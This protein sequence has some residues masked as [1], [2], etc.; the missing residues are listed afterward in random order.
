[1]HILITEDDPA[2]CEIMTD[3]FLSRG[4]RIEAV[5]NGTDTLV[6]LSES[7][8]DLLLLD[9]NLP[10]CSGFEICDKIR[11]LYGSALP[12]LFITARVSEADKL[13]GYALG[14]DDY[15]TKPF[16][17]PV[18]YAKIE[19]IL[20]RHAGTDPEQYGSLTLDPNAHTVSCMGNR[21]TL[22]AKEY[23]LLH[24]LAE[25]QGRLFTREQ[26]LIRIWG[27]DYEGSDRTVDDHIRKLRQ[28]LGPCRSYIRT[29]Y[30]SGYRFDPE[31][32]S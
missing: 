23:E 11:K 12:V 3:Y 7:M 6:K 25:N 28:K 13:N 17:L 18:L 26:L 21:E 27:Y 22:T 9:I 8:P 4:Y 14:A 31:D 15:I 30:G 29:I 20:R 10:D 5:M 24:F 32:Q 1:M 19:A 2:L 16:S